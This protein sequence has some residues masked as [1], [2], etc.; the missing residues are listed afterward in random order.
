MKE[1]KEY[2]EKTLTENEKVYTEITS[3][4][5]DDSLFLDDIKNK[6]YIKE[7]DI[8][9]NPYL[10][11]INLSNIKSENISLEM[12]TYKANQLF[13]SN[14]YTVKNLKE[15]PNFG[16]FKKDTQFPVIYQDNMPW[17]SIVPS[18]INT[19]QKDIEEMSGNILILGCGLGYI[20]YMLS[21]KENVDKITIVE[22]NYNIIK[23]FKTYILPQFK[24]KEKINIILDDA[25]YFLSTNKNNYDY[26]YSDI[27]YNGID[28]LN[29]YLKIKPFEKKFKNTRF[30]YWIEDE[31]L[32]Q[33]RIN[34]CENL[35]SDIF[36]TN[37]KNFFKTDS[38]DIF[39][40]LLSDDNLKNYLITCNFIL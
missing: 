24:N 28:G 37:Q 16:Y 2:I 26:I 25:T 1:I 17:M 8:E 34:I 32:Q 9:N 3:F 19:M 30:I 12:C 36:T 23:I 22:K 33:L 38:L 39:L 4:V 5:E 7:F 35:L 31:I 6:V 40:E 13:I 18:E 14:T 11:N 21:L 29:W 10:K 15:T 20:A 27:W